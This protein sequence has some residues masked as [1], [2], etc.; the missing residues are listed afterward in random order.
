[1][2]NR[3]AGGSSGSEGRWETET[4]NG[5]RNRLALWGRTIN[6]ILKDPYYLALG[7][8][9]TWTHAKP[10]FW[11]PHNVFL[12]ALYV[13]WGGVLLLGALAVYLFFLSWRH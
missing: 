11:I 4:P 12:F 13:G 10:A 7:Y 3:C 2:N 6:I 9:T 5:P 1:M 8:F